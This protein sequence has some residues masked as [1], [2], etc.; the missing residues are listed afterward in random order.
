M[1]TVAAAPA[2]QVAQGYARFM[3]LAPFTGMVV[4]L[5]LWVWRGRVEPA[6]LW[7]CLGFYVLSAVGVE[8]G[9]HRYF[10][11]RAFK[12]RPAFRLMLGVLG[13]IAGQ[14]PVLYWVAIHRAHHR[15]S[16]TERDPHSP[17][18]GGMKRFWHA[19]LGWM[20]APR[21]TD[22]ARDAPDLA[23]DPT[24]L[25]VHKSYLPCF[26][27]GLVVPTLIGG[28][29]AG[30]A[31][32]LDGFLWG[33]WVR[34]FLNHHVTWSINSVCHLVGRRAFATRDGSRNLAIL[35]LPSFGGSWHNNHHAFP[36]SATNDRLW[37]Q[38]DPGAWFIRL[39]ARGGLAWDV[40]DGPP[41]TA[42]DAQPR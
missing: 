9:F 4:A 19:H 14:G 16:D 10:S 24:T 40:C 38:L 34:M 8:V 35:A 11:H 15:H 2:R 37:W 5:A 12:T 39:A 22:I 27:F 6:A 3:V 17:V 42:V 1:T 41:A 25:W 36:R 29:A 13:S 7:L 30:A 26:A 20:F 33:G 31:G 28:V 21:V 23:R 18:P 32:A